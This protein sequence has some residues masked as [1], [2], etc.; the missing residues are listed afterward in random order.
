MVRMIANHVWRSKNNVEDNAGTV[1]K[2]VLGED[3]G[4]SLGVI[5]FIV[6]DKMVDLSDQNNSKNPPKFDSE[7]NP[8]VQK[9]KR[10]QELIASKGNLL[11]DMNLINFQRWNFKQ[12]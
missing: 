9:K 7:H 8:S 2:S 4:L 12:S 1:L 3:L 11:L 5:G 10:K 6:S